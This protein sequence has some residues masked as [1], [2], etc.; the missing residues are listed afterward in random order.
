M[1]P[2]SVQKNN[3]Q[4]NNIYMPNTPEQSGAPT[5][6]PTKVLHD[7]P[8]VNTKTKNIGATSKEKLL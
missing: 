1:C 3:G 4:N 2:A 7:L 5:Q 8:G 6:G